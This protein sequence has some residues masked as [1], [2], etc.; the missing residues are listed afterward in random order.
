MKIL[1]VTIKTWNIK[2][3]NNF[4]NSSKEHL[5][6]IITN[7]EEFNS[8]SVN[9]FSPDY[10]FFPHWSWIIPKEI[11]EKYKCVVFHMTDLPFGRGGS[12]LQNLIKKGIADTKISA[13]LVSEELDAGKVYMK[14]SLN[15]NGT[16]DEILIRAS[17]IV[18]YKLI[19]TIIESDIIPT[20][21]SGDIV[22]F[23]RRK[24]HESEILESI[25][26]LEKLY[27]HIRMLDGE[28]YPKAF[29]KVGKFIFEFSRASFKGEHIL[30]DVTI[31][32]VENE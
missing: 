30:S 16:A 6:K 13:I 18:F 9:D 5:V 20:T 31:R 24:P 17:K 28:G 29:V 1:I 10:I 12:P 2:E 22:C 27:D 32:E 3:A 19:P 14:H 4:K 25:S 15:L 11:F 26:N 8:V 23:K 21:Q 7:P